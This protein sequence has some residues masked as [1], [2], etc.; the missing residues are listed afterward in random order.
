[1]DKYYKFYDG[2]YWQ[3][4]R[5]ANG[6]RHYIVAKFATPREAVD[7]AHDCNTGRIPEHRLLWLEIKF[8]HDSEDRPRLVAEYEDGLLI[9]TEW[10]DLSQ[11]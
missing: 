11:Y 7:F 9:V 8:T 5:V 10:K 4:R 3:V 1:M 6:E 2:I